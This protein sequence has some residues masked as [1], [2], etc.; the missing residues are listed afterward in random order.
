V[1]RPDWPLYWM[2]VA[3]AVAA[4]ADCTRRRVGAVIVDQ[5]NR[6]IST[7]Y[8]GAPSGG[9]SCLAGQCP[10]GRYTFE[11]IPQGAPY[12]GIEPC[13]AVH[14]ET[15]A[16]MYGDPVRMRNGVIYVNTEICAGCQLNIRGM[17]LRAFHLL[18]G[19]IRAL[20]LPKRSR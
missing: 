15:N 2:G 8:N 14:A 4:R 13:I 1:S 20:E 6:I 12:D 19:G 7:G 5:H 11:V 16:L 9:P 18:P 3:E 17:G 10:R